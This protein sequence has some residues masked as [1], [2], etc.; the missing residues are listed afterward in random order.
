MVMTRSEQKPLVKNYETGGLAQREA[1]DIYNFSGLKPKGH[2]VLLLPYE[3]QVK[4]SRLI[5]PESVTQRADYGIVVDVGAACWCDEP[6]ARAKV[7]DR[8]M[9]PYLSGRIVT[10]PKDGKSYRAVNDKDIFMQ[11]TE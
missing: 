11:V 7:G 1:V 3:P 2:C 9:V 5:L 8:V 4:G 10:G 6:E